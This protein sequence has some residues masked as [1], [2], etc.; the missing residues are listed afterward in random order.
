[1]RYGVTF[2]SMAMLPY[3]AGGGEPLVLVHGLAGTWRHWKPLL[4]ALE[5]RHEVIAVALAGH[6]E[7]ALDEGVTPS[8]SSLADAL[9]ADLDEAGVAEADFVGSSL[10]AWLSFELARRGRARSVVAISP[11]GGWAPQSK[12]EARIVKLFAKAHAAVRK[13]GPR[14]ER[15][16]LR[17]LGRWFLLRRSYAH[18]T[19]REAEE[20]AYEVRAFAATSDAIMS[21]AR[22][23]DTWPSSNGVR[24]EHLEEVDVPV[25]ILWGTK[26]KILPQKRYCRLLLD[27]LPRAE[28]QL[29]P[30]AGHLAMCDD[31]EAVAKAILAFTERHAPAPAAA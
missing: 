21:W 26:D 13:L 2:A 1:M 11:A 18:P 7:R 22:A 3:R 17:K 4:P 31:P 6:Y 19:R 27:A 15:L 29:L 24:V 9:E 23:P 14:A 30:G 8:I 10:G 25:L 20:A 5:R 12:E 16:A 28:L